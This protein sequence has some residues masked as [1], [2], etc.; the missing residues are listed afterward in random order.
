MPEPGFVAPV[1]E[2]RLRS[3]SAV[4][5]LSVEL[6]D[7]PSQDYRAFMPSG[8]SVKLALEFTL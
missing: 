5:A 2:F 7:V 8:N 3:D 6:V 1:E 4:L